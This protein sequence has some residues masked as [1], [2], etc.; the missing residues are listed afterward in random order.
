MSHREGT[1][2]RIR[3]AAIRAL[4]K[5]GYADLSIKRIGE[6]LGQSSSLLYHY[7]DDKDDLLLSTLDLVGEEFV[8]QRDHDEPSNPKEDLADLIDA[9]FDPFSVTMDDAVTADEIDFD[10]VLVYVYA[11]L[12]AQA[13]RDERYRAKITELETRFVDEITRT[14]ERGIEEGQFRETAPT[15]TAEH[16]FALFLHELHT[17]TAVD[18]DEAAEMTRSNL[19]DLTER[20][21]SVDL[22]NPE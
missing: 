13:T 5:H 21:L 1:E 4:A 20:E 16:I 17:K 8:N 10:V 15:K 19:Y 14:L 6:E 7:F 11:E 12:W 3:V 9:F 18:R 22:R 2:W